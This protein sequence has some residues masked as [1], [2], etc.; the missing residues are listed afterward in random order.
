MAQHDSAIVIGNEN[1]IHVMAVIAALH[2][3]VF[4]VL[5]GPGHLAYILVATSSATLLWATVFYLDEQKRRKG[6]IAAIL[7]GLI[8]QQVA[9]QFWK[10]ELINFW[11][12]LAQFWALHFFI[13]YGLGKT[14]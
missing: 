7:V 9:Y 2:V 4:N 12:A 1:F 8:V 3:V 6:T 10:S 5:F 11:W 14:V 13:A